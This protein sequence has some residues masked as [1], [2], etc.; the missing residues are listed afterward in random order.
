[1]SDKMNYW[2]LSDYTERR[3]KEDTLE[4]MRNHKWIP[5]RMVTQNTANTF[6]EKKLQTVMYQ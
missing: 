3:C 6:S 2:R 4:R 5:S 1:M